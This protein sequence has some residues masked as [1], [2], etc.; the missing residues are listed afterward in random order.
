M[1][2]Y[3]TTGNELFE[4]QIF[5]R[6]SETRKKTI[7]SLILYYLSCLVRNIF[8]TEKKTRLV[9]TIMSFITF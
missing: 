3:S 1:Q 5:E 8:E 9:N 7:I 6:Q 4:R 2:S